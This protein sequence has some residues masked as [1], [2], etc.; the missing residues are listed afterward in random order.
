ML[1]KICTITKCRIWSTADLCGKDNA[2][3]KIVALLDNI[4]NCVTLAGT[5]SVVQFK[6]DVRKTIIVCVWQSVSLHVFAI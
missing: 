2:M 1:A 4:V 6:A 5:V 3:G